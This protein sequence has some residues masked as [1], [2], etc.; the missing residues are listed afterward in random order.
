MTVLPAAL[1][2]TLTQVLGFRVIDRHSATASTKKN[3]DCQDRNR[4][5]K[6]KHAVK[7]PKREETKP[8]ENK[9]LLYQKQIEN[10]KEI[11]T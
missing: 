1:K 9:I 11:S 7:K 8:T 3:T 2:Q 5:G 6:E 4:Y 10:R